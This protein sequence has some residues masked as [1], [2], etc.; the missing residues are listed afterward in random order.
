M[1][2]KLSIALLIALLLTMPQLMWAEE[3]KG[4][5]VFELGEVVVE[6]TKME[7]KEKD[8]PATVYVIT[9]EDIEQTDYRNIGEVLQ[10]IPGVFTQDK[11]HSGYNVI[12]FR[13]VGL[14]SHVTRGILVLV[15]GISIN[16]ADGRVDFEGIDLENVEKIEVIKGPVSALYGSNGMSGVINIVTKKIPDKFE[17]KIKGSIGSFLT[18]EINANAG[19]RIG[20]FGLRLNFT[21]RG[22]DGYRKR[23]SWS[24]DTIDSKFDVDLNRYGNLLFSADYTTSNKDITGPL[25]KEQYENRSE[26]NTKNFAKSDI[27]LARLGLTHKKAWGESLDLTTNLFFRNKKHEGGYSDTSTSDDELNLFGGEVRL[28]KSFPLLG[29]KD[30]LVSGISAEREGGDS[31]TYKL[32]ANGNKTK[33]TADGNSIYQKIG[34]YLHNDYNV[35]DPLMLSLGVRYDHVHYNWKDRLQ[36]KVDSSDST[37]VSAWSPKFGLAYN[38]V[39]NLT[40]FGNIGRGFNPPLISQLFVGS[41]TT[42]PNP[43]LKPEY[44]T[45]YEVGARGQLLDRLNYSISFF[46]MEF[47][48]QML[49]DDDTG[50]Y[51]N[52]G[53]TRHQGIEVMADVNL[54]EGLVFSINYAYLDAK[55]TDYPGY[56][57]NYIKNAPKNQGGAGLTYTHPGG[58]T[59]NINLVWMGKYYMDNENVNAYSGYCVVNTKFSYKWKQFFTSFYINNLFNTNYAT[60]AS[61]SYRRGKWTE[62]YYPGWPFN[63]LFTVGVQF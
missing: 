42:T 33:L 10:K 3:E 54:F 51:E 31:K 29:R 61:A 22:S 56:D 41:S 55:F 43:D 13:G 53:D 6:A 23:N 15:D 37:S 63:I 52:A 36:S 47:T 62:S 27:D 17:P 21:D 19:G 28:L 5:N 16:Q 32:D 18:R 34:C 50:K 1:R 57:G 45:N 2:S 7:K 4:E 44:L 38:P 20:K 11:Y 9:K 24:S 26:E 59:G 58:F 8:I 35:L 40:I 30:S 49:R 60:W 46:R 14:H 12:S 39:E 25:D 48:D